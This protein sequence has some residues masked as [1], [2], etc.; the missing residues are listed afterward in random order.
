[1]TEIITVLVVDDDD[2][3]RATLAEALVLYGYRVVTA[4]NG[5]EA[6]AR[7]EAGPRA[8]VILLDLMMPVMDGWAFREAQVK[9]AGAQEIPVVVLS[10]LTGAEKAAADLEARACLMKP[11]G[12]DRL[13]ET[14]EAV[15][16][17]GQAA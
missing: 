16:A 8:D 12:L 11:V 4:S 14:I 3:L 2:D 17:D 10:A 5:K 13:R 9:V 6:L 15:V 7:L 1:M